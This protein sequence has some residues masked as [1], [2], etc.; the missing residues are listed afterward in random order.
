MAAKPP[1][2]PGSAALLATIRAEVTTQHQP[3]GRAQEQERER[4]VV[5]WIGGVLRTDRGA[6]HCP[7]RHSFRRMY[8]AGYQEESHGRRTTP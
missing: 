8:D 5:W 6:V 2:C 7:R 3:R 1:P 4:S